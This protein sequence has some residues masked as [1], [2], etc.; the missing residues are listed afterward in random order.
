MS[1]EK[2]GVEFDACCLMIMI[3]GLCK[4]GDIIAAFQVFDKFP[5]QGY[6]ESST[7]NRC[8]VLAMA[9]L[10]SV[11]VRFCPMQIFGPPPMELWIQD[12]KDMRLSYL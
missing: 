4:N 9:A 5:K 12:A 11:T 1:A 7:E 10:A 8:R 3:K 2:L 6:G